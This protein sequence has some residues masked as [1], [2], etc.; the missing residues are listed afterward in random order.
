MKLLFVRLLGLSRA[1]HLYTRLSAQI[2]SAKRGKVQQDR[3]DFISK[4]SGLT[5]ATFAMGAL[6]KSIQVDEDTFGKVYLPLISSQPSKAENPTTIDFS[7]LSPE[8]VK[9]FLGKAQNEDTLRSFEDRLTK[10]Y[11]TLKL[12]LDQ[13]QVLVMDGSIV[14]VNFAVDSPTGHSSFEV[15]YDKSTSALL[16]TRSF[17]AQYDILGNIR[18]QCFTNEQLSTDIV[19]SPTGQLLE[20]YIQAP[21][22]RTVAASEISAVEIPLRI[23]QDHPL[24]DEAV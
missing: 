16:Q 2:A 4:A 3:R 17:L 5:L 1:L 12:L 19:V 7:V 22:G 10:N 8:E 20:G 11:P 9:M 18:V 23:V 6:P 13:Y 14:I 15:R 21:D 24:A